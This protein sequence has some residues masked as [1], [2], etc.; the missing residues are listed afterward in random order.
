MQEAPKIKVLSNQKTFGG[1]IKA[2][3]HWSESNKCFM[4]FNIFIPEDDVNKQRGAPFPVLYHL[5]GLTSNQD[6]GAWKSGFA[7]HASKHRIAI[8]FPDTSPR[9]LADYK[10]VGEPSEHWYVGYGAGFYV[11]AVEE[12]W[13]K[14]FNMYTY[15][16]KELP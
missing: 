2:V 8:V 12:P 5:G 11:D 4:K 13:N 9:D 7:Q 10:P 3:Q 6:N 1:R 16:T 14:N 15:I